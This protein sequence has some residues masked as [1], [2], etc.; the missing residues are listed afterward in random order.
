VVAVKEAN[1]AQLQP[2]DGLV[3]L[4]GNDEDL[5]R[6][7][8]MGG[9]GGICVATHIVGPRMRELH[10][11]PARRTE[12]D[13]SLRD[14]YEML[15]ITANPICCKAALNLLGHDVGGLRLPLVEADASELAAVRAVLE[16]HGL[17]EAAAT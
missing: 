8:D 7:L 5:A 9:G 2:I 11:D 4:A 12:I 13:A 10:D 16:R 6:C 1:G 17:L 15:F 3:V 14:V